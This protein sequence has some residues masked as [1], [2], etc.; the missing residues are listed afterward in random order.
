MFR[1]GLRWWTP[2]R[3]IN[4][5]FNEETH[6][7]IFCKEKEDKN[8]EEYR[9]NSLKVRNGEVTPEE[10]EKIVGSVV[11]GSTSTKKQN[12]LS[13]F[14]NSIITESFENVGSWLFSEVVIPN[15]KKA[16][17][18]L[19]T[20]GVD[21]LLYGKASGPRS[22]SSSIS[23][24]SYGSYY[25]KPE[26]EVVRAGSD[27]SSVTYDDI[28][29][30]SRGDAEAVITAMEDVIGKYGSV[31]VADFFELSDVPAPNYTLNK[32]VW[33]SVRNAQVLRCRDGYIIKMPRAKA[34]DN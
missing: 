21:M 3:I 15:I 22:S 16:I 14:A 6:Y 27:G 17:S 19:V 20:N 13:K 25:S 23:K 26:R 10:P 5:L 2:L 30:S 31:S 1:R 9:S 24:V 29:F 18:D 12:G 8:L 32:Y 11:T 34:I 33:T 28:I 4:N 7:I